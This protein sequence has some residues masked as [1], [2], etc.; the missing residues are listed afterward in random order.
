M[1]AVWS[2]VRPDL[3]RI[4]QQGLFRERLTL[5]SPQA[6]KVRICSS[7]LTNFCS[8][9]YLSLANDSRLVLKLQEAARDFGVGSGA[10]PLVCGR[11]TA[12]DELERAIAEFTGRDKAVL[13]SSGYLANLA[14][15]STFAGS[16]HAAIFQDK[17]NHA[18]MVDGALLSRGRFQ[19]YPHVDVKALD[20]LLEKS[21]HKIKLV[22]TDSVFSMDGDLAPLLEISHLASKHRALLAVDDAHGFGVKGYGGAGSLSE[23]GLGQDAVPLMMATLGKAVGC[24]GAFVA[25]RAELVELLIQKARPYIYS[26]SI[27]SAIAATAQEGLKLLAEERPRQRLQELIRYFRQQARS[28]GIPL[29]PSDTPIQP[30]LIGDP[31][32]ATKVSSELL[33]QGFLVTAIRPPTVPAGTSRLRITL[34]AG[35]SEKDID[36]LLSSLSQILPA[37]GQQE[38]EDA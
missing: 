27:P 28:R 1:G 31:E 22:L 14:I 25:G 23:L 13:F 24:S 21:Q 15:V 11:S 37:C 6:P 16:R 30:L 8:N 4:K 38:K 19:R 20:R 26:T 12:H 18:S 34:C 17:L 10:S 7:E 5:E 36:G 2:S 33:D 32:A 29:S 35:H 9:D 3:D